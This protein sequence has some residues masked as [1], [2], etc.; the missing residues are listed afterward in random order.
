M[1]KVN[2]QSFIGLVHVEIDNAS[3]MQVLKCLHPS[4]IQR[5]APQLKSLLTEP[6]LDEVCKVIERELGSLDEPENKVSKL[7]TI[8]ATYIYRHFLKRQDLSPY[9]YLRTLK[10]RGCPDFLESIRSMR[11]YNALHLA[12]KTKRDDFMKMLFYTNSWGRL[13]ID[14]VTAVNFR[15]KSLHAGYTPRRLVEALSFETRGYDMLNK[16]DRHDKVVRNLSPL[17]KACLCGSLE[18]VLALVD[19]RPY[20]M[21]HKDET[22]SNCL[23]Y[24]CASGNAKLVDYLLRKGVP[25]GVVNR[26]GETPLHITAMCG[27]LEVLEVFSAHLRSFE[28][29]RCP[30]KYGYAAVHYCAMYGDIEAL[31]LY[32]QKDFKIDP[33]AL[34]IAAKYRRWEAFYYL[35][36]LDMDVTQGANIEDRS[37]VH[38]V[39]INGNAHALKQL[40]ERDQSADV[41]AKSADIQAK[42]ADV[43]AKSV[44]VQAKSVDVR[45]KSADIRAKSADVQAKSV[46]VQAKSVDVRAKSADVRAVDKWQK[47]LL[48]LA[49][50][51]GHDGVMQILIEEADKKLCLS[52]LICAHDIY[53]CREQMLIVRGKDRGRKAWHWVKLKR[54]LARSFR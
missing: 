52:D 29:G 8:T 9:E 40:F 27:H 51:H 49:A 33:K 48:H 37:A 15:H 31:R 6:N 24:A 42:S 3:V 11:G 36:E 43:R 53:I 39:V 30:N 7:S 12:I 14:C 50:D 23:F 54:L 20:L 4:L 41:R 2:G 35:L 10:K 22:L 13:A 21:E 25:R 44:D 38:Y 19:T 47:N 28:I 1:F 46:D 32:K 45:A 26:F 18:S 16:F 34:T 5:Q 17:C